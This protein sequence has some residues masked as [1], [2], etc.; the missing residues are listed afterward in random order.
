MRPTTDLNNPLVSI[1][2]FSDDGKLQIVHAYGNGGF[3]IAKQPYQG[4]QLVAMRQTFTWDVGSAEDITLESL[5]PLIEMA[6]ELIL[7]GLGEI[8]TSHL[9]DIRTALAEQQI[10]MDVMN[11]AAACRTWNVLLTEGRKAA[12]ALIAIE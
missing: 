1:K 11:T 6:P 5:N 3:R 10:K 8:A 2:E 4:H 7:F 9:P 12:A